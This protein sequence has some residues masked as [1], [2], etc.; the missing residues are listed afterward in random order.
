[1]A[2][3][4]A[5]LIANRLVFR[6]GDIEG[7]FVVGFLRD[8]GLALLFCNML[9]A[10]KTDRHLPGPIGGQL[11]ARLAGFSYSLYCT[12]TPVLIVYAAAM[13]RVFGLGWHMAPIGLVPWLIVFG[14]FAVS[15][16]V[17]Y[18]FALAT[19]AHT[20]RIRRALF[21]LL[22]RRITGSAPEQARP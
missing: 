13:V 18:L 4:V 11:H 3:F 16:A 14:A 7:D 21:A 9:I 8:L 15:L 12:H 22:D 17:A 1:M 19:E 6:R 2:L 5:A 20:D 10:L